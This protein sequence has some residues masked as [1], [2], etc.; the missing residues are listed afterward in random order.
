MQHKYSVRRLERAGDNIQNDKFVQDLLKGGKNI[1][2]EV[3]KFRG[4]SRMCSSTI[5]GVVGSGNISEHFA[6]IY[7]DLYS[8]VELDD[9][10]EEVSARI[11]SKIS[12]DSMLDV[13]RVTDNLVKE[14]LKKM[15][16]GKSD[17][18]YDFSSDCIINGP[19]TLIPHLTNLVKLFL[20]HG[21]APL[22]LLV[23]SLVPLVKDNLADLATSDNYRAIAIGSLLLKLLDWVVLLLE[24]DKLNVDQLQYGYQALTSTTMCSWSLGAT[25]EYY[26]NRGRIVY[27]CAMDCSKAFDMVRWT[28]LFNQLMDCGVSPICLR[29]IMFIYRNQYCDV[30]WNGKFSHR[31]SVSNGVRQG[32]VSSPIFFCIYVDQLVQELR[33]SEL[34]CRIGG[35]YLGV[36]VYADDIFLLS[37]SRNGLQSMVNICQNFADNFNLKFSTNPDTVKSKTKCIVFS[38]KACDRRGLSPILLKGLPL[39]WVEDLK[40]LGNTLQSDNSM[41]IDI[42]VKRGQFI[43]KVHSLNQE[44]YFC[45]PNVVMNLYRIYNCSFYSSSL[46]DLF[47]NKLDQ[48]YSTWNKTVR[49][50]FNLPLDTHTYLIETV[51]K[52]LHPK[53][54]LSSR[55]ISFHKTNSK[56]SRQ[57]I[58]LLT[59]ICSFDQR[60]AY[61]RNLKNIS[62][63]CKVPIEDL[64]NDKVKKL[65]KFKEIPDNEAWRTKLVDELLGAKFGTLEVPLSDAELEDILSYACS[66]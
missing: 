18:L 26:N 27:G 9:E 11:D 34:G 14:A 5:D 21:K 40:H 1:F 38:Q 44:F 35:H 3:K 25:V 49:I 24:G 64:T 17:A 39:P 54:M 41:K 12:P 6:S 33:R 19:K 32:A 60:T 36:A 37:A 45:N 43:G 31:F 52:S 42:S 46:Y 65:M 55:F 56:S 23:C 2:Q 8:K 30:R 57:A 59:N 22:F 7:S 66:S 62:D 63:E 47:S 58:Q 50:L 13:D 15:K 28:Q 29:L 61:G 10:F 4:K 16:A 51:S 48:L 20:I 53:V